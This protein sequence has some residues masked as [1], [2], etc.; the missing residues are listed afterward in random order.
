VWWFR[1]GQ[2][3][4]T[5]LGDDSTRIDYALELK[6]LDGWLRAASVVQ[7]AGLLVLVGLFWLLYTL[8]VP[9]PQPGVRW[10]VLQMFQVSHVLWPPFLLIALYR[11]WRQGV[12]AQFDTF[13]H[14]LPYASRV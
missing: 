10:Q 9:A 7:L 4:L 3:R 2:L 11:R 13:L 14:N 8:V 6:P 5:P 1:R 12:I